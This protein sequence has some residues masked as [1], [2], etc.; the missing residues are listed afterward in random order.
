[1]K[2]TKNVGFMLL[3]LW[4]IVSGASAL[5]DLPIPSLGLLLSCLAVVSGIFILMGK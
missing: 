4:L 5:V 2:I 1:M 3:G